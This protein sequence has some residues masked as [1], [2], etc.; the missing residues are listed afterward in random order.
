MRNENRISERPAHFYVAGTT[1]DITQC[2][3]CFREDLK[4]TTIIRTFD[5]RDIMIEE[6]HLGSGCASAWISEYFGIPK[7]QAAKSVAKHLQIQRGNDYRRLQELTHILSDDPIRTRRW[8]SPTRPTR[9][10]RSSA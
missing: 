9:S 10:A 1:K 5:S 7:H 4:S 8:T 2:G 3:H 6:I